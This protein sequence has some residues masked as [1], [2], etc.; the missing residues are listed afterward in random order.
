[1]DSD[2]ISAEIDQTAQRIART[3]QEL[4]ARVVVGRQRFTRIVILATGV[5]TVAAAALAWR[6][7]R[8]RASRRRHTGARPMSRTHLVSIRSRDRSTAARLG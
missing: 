7:Y 4:D 1:M 2:L 6:A 3:L 8:R 5:V